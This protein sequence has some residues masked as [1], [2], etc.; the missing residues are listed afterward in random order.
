MILAALVEGAE[1]LGKA[2]LGPGDDFGLEIQVSE[3]KKSHPLPVQ[4]S[5]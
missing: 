5:S 3:L 2:N 1:G 4:K